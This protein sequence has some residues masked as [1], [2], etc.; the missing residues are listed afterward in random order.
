MQGYCA[1]YKC[2]LLRGESPET[3]Y[4]TPISSRHE[5]CMPCICN[6]IYHKSLHGTACY[7]LCGKSVNVMLEIAI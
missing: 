3:K 2:T 5:I 6:T 4:L 7:R 1:V